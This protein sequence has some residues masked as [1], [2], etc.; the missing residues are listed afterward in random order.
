[1][2]VTVTESRY[3]QLGSGM[4]DTDG[5][6]IL[7]VDVFGIPAAFL[8]GLFAYQYLLLRVTY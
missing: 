4:G 7:D 2:C 1:M 8:H 3:S 5:R 6:P